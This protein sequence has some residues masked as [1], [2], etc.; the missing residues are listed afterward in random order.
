MALD[1]SKNPPLQPDD[2][3]SF[4]ELYRMYDEL[5]R[6]RQEVEKEETLAPDRHNLQIRR[7]HSADIT[8]IRELGTSIKSP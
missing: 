8:S 6:L 2:P 3:P 5:L 4:A 7:P 1:M